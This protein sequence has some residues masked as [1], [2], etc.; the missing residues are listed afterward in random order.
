MRYYKIENK[1]QSKEISNQWT[2]NGNQVFA[3]TPMGLKGLPCSFW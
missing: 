1:M 2:I 3:L